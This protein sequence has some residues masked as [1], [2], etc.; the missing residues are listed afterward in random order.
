MK[1]K[2][3]FLFLLILLQFSCDKNNTSP[4]DYDYDTRL[5]FED[6]INNHLSPKLS[7][8]NIQLEDL[9]EL[10]N[11]FINNPN[12][13]NLENLRNQFITVYHQW[14]YI[15]PFSFGPGE[16]LQIVKKVNNF[17]VNYSLLEANISAGTYDI[18]AP[19][20]YY[21]GLPAIDYLL[22]GIANDDNA[23][24]DLY[25]NNDNYKNYLNDVVNNIVNVSTSFENEWE[26]YKSTFFNNTGNAA[27]S[28]LSLMI[29]AF[30]E[31]YERTKRDRL[32]IPSGQ[33]TMGETF[34]EKLEG[35]FSGISSDLLIKSLESSQQFFNGNGSNGLNDLLDDANIQKDGTPLS[36]IINQQFQSA[37]TSVQ[38]LPK[39]LDQSIELH[40]SE[41]VSA[42]SEI[43]RQ[44]VYIKTDMP[45]ALCIAITYIDN[46][47][48]SD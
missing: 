6:I 2:G 3:F 28:S 36:Q 10:K 1:N 31:Q 26:T 29:N 34:P 17:P 15:E 37:I 40:T 13:T 24:I 46:P 39:P 23:I 7:N 16:S 30:N 5:I 14:Q 18:N 27:G 19:D 38:Q 35:Y 21:S 9:N 4:C 12:Y 42:Y 43:A 25:N 48:D 44:V 20:N 22:Y 8:F 47:S 32:A 45:S 33:I 11:T 41:V